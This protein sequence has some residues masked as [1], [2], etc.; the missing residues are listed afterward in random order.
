MSIHRWLQD[1]ILVDLPLELEKH[2]ELQTVVGMVRN[3]SDCDIVIDFSHV[4]VVGGACLGEGRVMPHREG[5]AHDLGCVL[6]QA[7]ERNME[8]TEGRT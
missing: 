2:S 8:K 1:V 7:A 4:D 3:G 5:L 6:W